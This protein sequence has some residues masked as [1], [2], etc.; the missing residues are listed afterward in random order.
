MTMSAS[1]EP[2]VQIATAI[3]VTS[4]IPVRTTKISSAEFSAMTASEQAPVGEQPLKRRNG[5]AAA[6]LAQRRNDGVEHACEPRPDAERA[7]Q[8]REPHVLEI[9]LADLGQM[10]PLA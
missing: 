10:C 4:E 9:G 7:D 1:H 5:A 6:S 2:A 3:A 8:K